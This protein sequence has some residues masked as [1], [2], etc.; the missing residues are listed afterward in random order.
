M[1]HSTDTITADTI[2]DDQIR[3]LH[4]GGQPISEELHELCRTAL[5]AAVGSLRRAQARGLLADF[6]NGKDAKIPL[7]AMTITDD[8]IRELMATADRDTRKLCEIALRDQYTAKTRGALLMK[9]RRKGQARA[10][11]AEILNTRSTK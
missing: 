2:T 1:G 8:Q 4:D 6:L 5:Y 10:R 11:L 3:S 9:A 7:N